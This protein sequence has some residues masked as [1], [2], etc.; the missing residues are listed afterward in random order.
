MDKPAAN[1]MTDANGAAGG[2]VIGP[3]KAYGMSEGTDTPA[4]RG[5]LVIEGAAAPSRAPC[6]STRADPGAM[7]GARPGSGGA[8]PCSLSTASVP[9]SL[10]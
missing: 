7:R 5:I 4:G 1:F 2:A 9:N 10:R 8:A 3:V 6:W